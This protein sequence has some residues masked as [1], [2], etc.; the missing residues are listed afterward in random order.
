MGTGTRK[1]K[2]VV[3][4]DGSYA[5]IEALRQAQRIAAALGATPI[6]PSLSSTHPNPLSTPRPVPAYPG[7]Q[8]KTHK[9][10]KGAEPK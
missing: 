4:V 3:G 2:I 6:A 9:P 10:I 8:P 1:E 5:S 7:R